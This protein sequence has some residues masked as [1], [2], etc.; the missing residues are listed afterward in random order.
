[1]K[2]IYLT[3]MLVVTTCFAGFSQPWADN[4]PKDKLENGELT[5]FDIQEAFNQWSAQNNVVNGYIEQNGEQIKVPYWKLFKR[6]EYYWSDRIDPKTGKFPETSAS[7][8]FEKYMQKNGGVRSNSGNWTNM[9]VSSSSGGYAGIGRLNCIGFNSS[10][11]NILYVGS[12][13]GGL[14]KSANGGSTWTVLTDENIVLGVSDIIVVEGTPD[15]LYI[16]TGDRDGGSGWSM[17]GGQSNDNNSIGILKS[18]DGG[19]TWNTTGISWAASLNRTVNRI[20]LDPAD[21]TNQTLY[22]A[23]SVGLYKTTNGGSNWSL[24]SGTHFI[25]I[26]FKP[27]TSSTIYGSNWNGDIYYSTNSG[28]NWSTGISTSNYRTELAVSANSVTTVYAVMANSG[29]GLAGVYK[30]TNSGTSFTQVYAGNT[31]GHNILGY[32]SNG[33]GSTSDGQG[34]YDLCIAADPTDADNVYIGGVNTWKST[35]GGAAWTINNMWTSST[36]YNFVGAPVVH[37]D[38]HFLAF[39]NGTSTLFE[40]NDGGVYK[41]TNGGSSWTDLTDGMTISQIYRLGVSQSASNY[42]MTGLQ[43]NGSKAFVGGSWYDVI[44]GDGFECAIKPSSSATQYGSL[45]YGRFLRTTNT[46]SGA[47]DITQNSSGTPLNGLNETGFWVTPFIIDPNNNN[48]I[49]VGMVNV[50]KS[51][52]QGSAWTKISPWSSS[53]STLRSLAVAPSNSSYIYAAT[54]TTLY[55]TANG[56]T[57]WT[58]NLAGSLPTGSGNITYVSVKSNDPQTVWVSMGGYNAYG[59]YESTDGG[60]NWSDISSGLPSLPVM[61][62]IQ[63]KQNLAQNELYAATDVGVYVKVGTADWIPFMTGLPNVFVPELEIYYDNT[64]PSNSRI[65]AATF[66][67]GLWESDLYTPTTVAPV[68]EFVANN[69][70]PTGSG[71]LVYFTDQSSNTPTSWSWTITPGTIAYQGGT[72]STSQNPIVSFTSTGAYTVAFTA[73]NAIGS[74]IETKVA[75]IHMGTPGLW[76]GTTPGWSTTTNWDN[77]MVPV[78]ATDV[79]ISATASNWPEITGNFTIGNDCNSLTMPGASQFIVSGD[80]IINP[81]KQFSCDANATIFV[82]GNWNNLGTFNTGTSTVNFNGTSNGTISTSKNGEK[83]LVTVLNETFEGGS[84]PTGWSVANSSQTVIWSVD[85]S[86]NPPGYYSASYS[87]NYNNGTDFDDGNY[88][89]GSVTTSA[90]DNSESTATSISFYY[91]LETEDYSSFDWVMIEILDASDNSI[92]QTEGGDGVSIPEASTTWTLYTITGNATVIATPSIKLRFTFSTDDSQDNAFFGW[93][94]DDLKVEKNLPSSPFHNLVVSK[95]GGG[96]LINTLELNIGGNLSVKPGAYFTSTSG[97]TIDIANDLIIEAGASGTASFID[98]GTTTVTGSTYVQYYCTANNWHYMSASIDPQGNKFNAL[99]TNPI[100]AAFYRWDESH[101]EQSSYGWWIDILNSNEWN[102]DTFIPGQGYAIS[103]FSKAT[104]YSLSGD[105]YNNTKTLAMTKTSGSVGEGWNLVGNPFP[106]SM[107]ANTD[108]DGTNNFLARNSSVLDESFVALYIYNDATQQ[109]T[110]VSN[111]PGATYISNGQG[112]LVK[113]KTHNNNITFHA[114]DRKHGSATFYKGGDGTQR[115]Y[116]TIINPD[117]T[118]DETE[119]VFAEGMTFGL[120]PSFDAGKYK[121]NPDL[122]LY[123]K[124]IEGSDNDFAIQALPLLNQPVVVEVGFITGKQGNYSFTTELQNFDA[125]TPVTLVDKYTSNQVDLVSNPQYNFVVDEPGTFN[126]RFLIYFKSAVGIE[127]D[128][129]VA[130][131][132]FHIYTNGNQ[133]IISSTN[134]IEAFSVSVFNTIGQLMVHKEFKGSTNGQINIAPPGAY[135]VRVVSEKGVTTRK[136]LV[137]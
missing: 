14:W 12:P 29:G 127:D 25:D 32:Y 121:G 123:T 61:C 58:S 99:F 47:T 112:F 91:Q 128:I 131:D 35:N 48:T 130:H 136:V 116:L 111:N 132:N 49:Y 45:Y 9:G 44:G 85:A 94:I 41:T 50:W 4:I 122:S 10:N 103:D 83:T 109:Y 22:A 69:T 62:V 26:E 71:D 55:M 17:G 43:D 54:Q 80:F 119:I 2:T 18:T 77:H 19:A 129:E 65:R 15:I 36:S 125:N 63:N 120:N 13:S 34:S 78:S 134:E 101:Y 115:F 23:T 28:S 118:I 110:T 72:S 11:S 27:G 56:G 126:N 21:G 8:E 113:T 40:C 39:Q 30:S 96:E 114:D 68:A 102:D 73:T 67:R 95:S 106:C 16:A 79:T 86:P 76:K 93:F 124:L 108:A 1:M 53:G 74:G 137:R 51:T 6:W 59:V 5:F 7:D 89:N 38:Q 75:Y 20:L 3:F 133:V 42:V 60:S 105:S 64:T 46:W 37:A 52:T 66:G 107:A 84:M 24:L 33:S 87:L 82:G 117:Q 97:N 92:I 70:L 57:N 88:N 90:I 98:E 135:I 100:P 81:S 31:T 104:T